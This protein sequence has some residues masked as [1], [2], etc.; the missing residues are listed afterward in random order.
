MS[1]FDKTFEILKKAYEYGVYTLEITKDN[2][3]IVF[4]NGLQYIYDKNGNFLYLKEM[5]WIDE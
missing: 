5:S 4:S 3:K 1:D 2:K